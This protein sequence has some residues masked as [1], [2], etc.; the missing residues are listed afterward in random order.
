[1]VI[2]LTGENWFGLSSALKKLVAEFVNEHG[3]MALEQLDGETADVAR[4]NEALQSAPFLAS[5]KLV[6]LRN[7]SANKPFTEEAEKVLGSVTD[8]T[9]VVVVEQKLDKRLGYYKFLKKATDFREFLPLDERSAAQWLTQAAKERGGTLSGS[10]AGYLVERVGADQQLLASELDKLLLY[11]AHISKQ[12]IDLLTDQNVQ[13]TIFQ[14]LDAAFAGNK[15]RAIQLYEEQRAQKVDPLAIIAML[16]WQLHILALIVYAGGRSADEIAREAKV[17]PYT[18][19]KSQG[20]ART[21]G[22]TDIKR[23]VAELLD[24]DKRAR[25]EA[26]DIDAALQLYLLQLG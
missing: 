18:V 2:T 3:D 9:D 17:S 1:M 11:N 12:N 7:G 15:K 16:S 14:L 21:L 6:V 20:I 23:Y 26:L 10:D 13:S 4:I 25:R 24:I 5:K 8:S 19:K 22:R